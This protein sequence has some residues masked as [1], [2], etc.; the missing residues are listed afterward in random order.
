MMKVRW[1]ALWALVSAMILN[2]ILPAQSQVVYADDPEDLPVVT[3]SDTVPS[4]NPD[5]VKVNLFNYSFDNQSLDVPFKGENG[6][7]S[8]TDTGINQ[9]HALDFG[10]GISSKAY[11]AFPNSDGSSQNINP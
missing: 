2:C 11:T 10:Q 8:Y 5:H 9:G 6:N 7:A 4:A 3:S 1:M